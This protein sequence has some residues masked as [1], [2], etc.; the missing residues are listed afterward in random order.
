V[1]DL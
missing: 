1:E